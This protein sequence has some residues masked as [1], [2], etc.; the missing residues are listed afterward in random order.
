[1][2][3]VIRIDPEN[4]DP[5]V[6]EEALSVLRGGGLVVYPTDTVYGLGADPFNPEAVERVH[7]AKRRT[8][9]PLPLL[10][11]KPERAGLF[12]EVGKK[13][14]RLIEEFWPGQLTIILRLRRELPLGITMGTGKIALRVPDCKTAR[15]LAE[16]LGGAIIGTSANIS[17]A[18]SPRT[19]EEALAQLGEKVD[20]VLDA[21]IT[22]YRLS[23]TIIDLTADPPR[24]LRIG[25]IPPED[26]EA[27]I[28]PVKV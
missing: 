23:S 11:D 20:L 4:H 8:G 17:G 5:T 22:R 12:G 27:V 3:R 28:G 25:P 1:M 13:A 14:L 26:I 9:K 15:M 24:I 16:G 2:A 10:L 7:E 19:A 18:P 21:G 6:L